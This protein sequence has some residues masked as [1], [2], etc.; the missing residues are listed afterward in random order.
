MQ[1]ERLGSDPFSLPVLVKAGCMAYSVGERVIL[2]DTDT[3]GWA[4]VIACCTPSVHRSNI[5]DTPLYFSMRRK[6]EQRK[7]PVVI[8]A[9]SEHE[10]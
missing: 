2:T 8:Y 1:A 7:Q 6:G 4:L 5:R 9:I 3:D 10:S